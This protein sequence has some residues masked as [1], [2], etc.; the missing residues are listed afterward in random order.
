M[1]SDDLLKLIPAETRY[2][3][4]DNKLLTIVEAFKTRKHYLK[5][6][7]HEVLILTNHNNLYWFIETKILSFRQVRWAQ[8]LSCYHFW[9]DYRQGKANGAADALSQYL[10]QS[11]GE[12][13]ILCI[14]N[15]KIFYRLQS[16]L[17]KVSSL[18][19]NTSHLSPLLQVLICET[20]VLPQ[21]HR[22][23]DS[24]WGEIA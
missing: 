19:V 6:S 17:G 8:K 21:F 16:S 12:E 9:I 13:K 11:A 3:T 7:Q 5:G 10:Q 24:F 15:V 22:V 18:S 14:K 20:T 1:A 23:W 4:H 2:K